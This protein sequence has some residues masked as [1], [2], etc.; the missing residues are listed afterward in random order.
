MRNIQIGDILIKDNQL[1]IIIDGVYDCF[2]NDFCYRPINPDGLLGDIVSCKGW[3]LTGEELKKSELLVQSFTIH[4]I[5]TKGKFEIVR[6][7]PKSPQL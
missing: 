2:F 5:F 4:A 6:V 3:T 7:V 1:I